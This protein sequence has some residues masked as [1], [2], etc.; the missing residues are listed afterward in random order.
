MMG[1]NVM[2]WVVMAA[3]LSMSSLVRA[4]SIQVEDPWIRA[5]PPNAPALGAFMTLHNGAHR[6]LSLVAVESRLEVE[7]A[8]LHRTIMADGMMK[9][10]PQQ[11]M[12]VPAQ[13]SLELKPGSWHIMLIGPHQ[14][15]QAGDQV[16]L[17]LHFSDGSQTEVK[18]EV[19]RGEMAGMKM[20]HGSMHRH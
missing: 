6:E 5:A 4:G 20:D 9:M 11:Q 3:L 17:V 2:Q 15:P 16:D 1:R 19:R 13:G 7:A 18:A 10:V 14:V 12:V 8:E